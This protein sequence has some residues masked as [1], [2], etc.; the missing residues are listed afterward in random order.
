MNVGN[1]QVLEQIGVTAGGTLHL[2]RHVPTGVSA[3]LKFSTNENVTNG[4][5]HEYALL[6]SLD[7]PEIRKP[8]ALLEDGGCSALV[9]ALEPFP[10]EGLDAVL[11]RQPHLSL[12]V[13]L[14]IALQ[15]ARAL[16]ALHAAGI[17]HRDIRPPN[18]LLA[19]A[20]DK[21]RLTLAD[22]SRATTREG[23]PVL[24]TATVSD[25]AYVSPE[26]TGRM[27]RQP[28]YRTDFYSLGVMLYRLLTGQLPFQADDPMEWI[29]CHIARRP[30]PPAERR[31]GVLAALSAIVMKCLAK[32]AE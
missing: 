19:Q 12:P 28:D 1:Y 22:L 14:T 17:M 27:N 11:M 31:P 4:L 25:W 20:H 6:Q 29:H 9:L 24:R 32:T 21:V 7:V 16:E 26:Q 8:L 3:L 18:F 23:A 13:V 10:A 15:A 5:R 2:A 30:V